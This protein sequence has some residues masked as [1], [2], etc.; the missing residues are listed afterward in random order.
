MVTLQLGIRFRIGHAVQLQDI[1]FGADNKSVTISLKHSKTDKEGR[2]AVVMVKGPK[3]NR[4][5]IPT[6]FAFC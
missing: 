4:V 1:T 6:V 2:G 3:I 5:Q